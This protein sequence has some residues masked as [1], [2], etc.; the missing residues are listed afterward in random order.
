MAQEPKPPAV[1]PAA[2][3]PG[4][5]L[6]ALVGNR[7]VLSDVQFE[8]LLDALRGRGDIVASLRE[9]T[10]DQKKIN[11]AINRV[12]ARMGVEEFMQRLPRVP[13]RGS[14]IEVHP[15]TGAVR[16]RIFHSRGVNVLDVNRSS[17]C[18]TLPDGIG[19][20]DVIAHISFLNGQGE[21]VGATRAERPAAPEEACPDAS[22]QEKRSE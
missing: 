15:P 6:T 17:P 1:Q 10:A 12:G 5:Q 11:A 22:Y 18:V 7:G 14:R 8:R 13:R 19:P 9:L 21:V 16:M 2:T 20:N 4:D 3:T